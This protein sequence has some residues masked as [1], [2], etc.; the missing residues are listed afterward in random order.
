[1]PKASI[2][3]KTDA[4]DV[5]ANLAL[6]LD[7]AADQLDVAKL[8]VPAQTQQ[9][10]K[11]NTQQVAATGTENKGEKAT[12]TVTFTNCSADGASITVPAGTGVSSGG[13]TFITQKSIELQTSTPGC[14][15]FNGFT[16]AS[17][18][19]VAQKPGANYNVA[20]ANFT[21]AG[22]GNVQVKSDNAMS[23]GTDNNVKVVQQS[24]IDSAKQKLS[25]SMNSDA[26][27]NQLKQ[28]LENDSLMA[29][30]ETFYPGTPNVTTSVNVGDEA[31]NVTVTEAITF[32]MYGVK[33]DDLHKLVQKAVDEK[34][35]TKKQSMLD[36]GL[37]KARYTV[38]TAGAGAQLKVDVSTTATAGP[39]LDVDSLKEQVAGKKSGNVKDL[40]KANPGVVDV[41]VTYSPFWVTKG[42][43]PEK[44]TITFQKTS[45]TTDNSSDNAGSADE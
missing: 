40:I 36:D 42:P 32:T 3:V 20:A 39:H 30:Q 26:I 31:D 18:D 12:G 22:I 41:E 8:V 6:T 44:V 33:R 35:N 5:D 34:I 29:L 10:Q 25:S 7:T 43:K 28:N 17:V 11:S 14:K 2:V 1:M 16:S 45:A 24:D 13:L 4:T 19:V 21:A 9:Q 15:S 37:S 38:P 23:G 27:K